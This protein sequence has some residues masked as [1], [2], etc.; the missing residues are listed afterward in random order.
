MMSGKMFGSYSRIPKRKFSTDDMLESASLDANEKDLSS[1]NYNSRGRFS[2]NHHNLNSN[3]KESKH[4][5]PSERRYTYLKESTSSSPSP[6]N[7]GDKTTRSP[8]DRGGIP[9]PKGSIARSSII[10]HDFKQKENTDSNLA[11]DPDFVEEV[12]VES[13]N[14]IELITDS[15]PT[16]F[17]PDIE[18]P[19]RQRLKIDLPLNHYNYEN[20]QATLGFNSIS[21]KI[22]RI[23]NTTASAEKEVSTMQNKMEDVMMKLEIL[24]DTAHVVSQKLVALNEIA[25]LL[26]HSEENSFIF[27]FGWFLWMLTL[28]NNILT[29]VWRGI[30]KQNSRNS[31]HTHSSTGANS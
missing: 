9:L 12:N 16:I 3:D 15:D 14:H 24:N 6:H 31:T 21:D 28:I 4:N 11:P 1:G 8:K 20:V 26:D 13:V 30:K 29:Y 25:E 10:F 5:S 7:S 27:S 22:E 17:L 23:A 2:S 18:E 19:L